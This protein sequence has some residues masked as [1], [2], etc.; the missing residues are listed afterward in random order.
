MA[1]KFPALSK[2]LGSKGVPI[3]GSVLFFDIF[4]R[5]FG[6][7]FLTTL[8][9]LYWTQCKT[10]ENFM[11]EH[12]PSWVDLGDLRTIHNRIH[13]ILGV[14]FM[15]IPM[16]LHCVIIFLPPMTGT[17]LTLVF[18]PPATKVS[19]FI[20]NN[21]GQAEMFITH[22]N[23]W[24][25]LMSIVV[26]GI[27]FP[28]SMSNFGRK[29]YFSPTMLLHIFCALIF[30]IDMVRRAPHAQVPTL[31]LSASLVLTVSPAGV[32]YSCYCLLSGGQVRGSVVL[33][34][35]RSFCHSSRGFGL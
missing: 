19:P 24:R 22:D 12:H 30:T 23:V 6:R 28:F 2:S 34:H 20:W 8:N 7:V 1:I 35:R 29:Y 21:N 3:P 9:A 26:F 11:M 33:S 18:G 17:P 10:T 14:F 31:H 27:L 25:A 16:V 4:G 13:Y 15:A 5:I 32:L